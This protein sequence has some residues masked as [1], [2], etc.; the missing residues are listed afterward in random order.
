M[1]YDSSDIALPR[2]HDARWHAFGRVA[3]FWVAYLLIL[4][5][6]AIP[7]QMVPAA[8]RQ[9]VWG[10]LAALALLVVTRLLYAK[11]S[12]GV[13]PYLMVSSASV[14]RFGLGVLLGVVVYAATAW[15]VSMLAGSIRLERSEGLGAGSAL[16]ALA[17]VLALSSMEELGF[18]EYALRTLRGAMGSWKAQGIV[19]IAFALSHVAFGWPW[20]NILVGVFPSAL[21]FGAA[22]T[23]SGGLAMPIGLHAALNLAGW[24]V[25]ESEEPGLWTMVIDPAA[26]ARVATAAPV[27]SITVTLCAAAALWMWHARA[28]T[29]H[30]RVRGAPHRS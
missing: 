4:F 17:T 7:K 2:S 10:V 16:L 5:A 9:C 3:L 12:G 30:S 13:S 18:R 24:A 27:I 19:A 11:Q 26:Q 15:F 20:Q 6:A 28:L 14:G 23:A 8:W 1:A 22:A 25:G 29:R 21:L